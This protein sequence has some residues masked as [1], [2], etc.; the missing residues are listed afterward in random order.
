M[1]LL[2]YCT[3]AKPY[4]IQGFAKPFHTKDINNPFNYK[5]RLMNYKSQNALNGKIVGE[6]DFE[7]ERI[8]Y[9]ETD[10]NN[11]SFGTDTLTP[12]ELLDKSCLTI[13]E[14][15]KYIGSNPNWTKG[16]YGYAI[17]IK[18]LKIYDKPKELSNYYH[19]G[20]PYTP[21]KKAP[22]NMM[23]CDNLK[24]IFETYIVISIRPD[25]L[26]QILNGKKTIEVRKK[27]LRRIL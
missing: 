4:L 9:R 6:C 20:Y 25:W 2:L 15:C 12:D 26:Y 11:Y 17:H 27:V 16:D 13:L 10:K 7:V 8:I 18:N 14:L 21:I 3:K 23:R 1:K 22:Q 24:N 19:R 5:W